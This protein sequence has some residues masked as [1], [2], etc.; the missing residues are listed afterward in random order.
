MSLEVGR[1]KYKTLLLGV[2]EVGK[3]LEMLVRESSGSRSYHKPGLQLLDFI[4]IAMEAF[5][6]G[7]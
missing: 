6:P 5:E 3:Y 2:N 7:E 1:T 4:L